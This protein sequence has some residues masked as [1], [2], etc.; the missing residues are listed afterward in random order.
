MD[1]KKFIWVGMTVGGFLGSFIP[2]LFGANEFSF[3]SVIFSAVGAM[4]GIYMAYKMS[5]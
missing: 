5:N 2:T 1:S 4:L 3:S